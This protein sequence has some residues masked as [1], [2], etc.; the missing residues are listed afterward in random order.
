[1][2]PV[3]AVTDDDTYA[4]LDDGTHDVEDAQDREGRHGSDGRARR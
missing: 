1:M 4:D 2:T 3:R